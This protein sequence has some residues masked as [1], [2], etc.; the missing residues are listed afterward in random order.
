MRHY[1]VRSSI[2]EYLQGTGY[3][4]LIKIPYIVDG[5]VRYQRLANEYLI[6]RGMGVWSPEWE[7]KRG[8]GT[9]LSK[10]AIKDYAL[11]LANFLEFA[12]A[13][14]ID[15]YTCTYNQHIKGRYEGELV[16]GTWSR[17]GV[18]LA[19]ATINAYTEQASCLLSWMAE[20]RKRETPFVVP[21]VSYVKRIGG[22]KHARG[23][24]TR[25]VTVR[26]GKLR[27]PKRRLRM[28]RDHELR[29]WLDDVY[30]KRE[31]AGGLICELV[32]MGALRRAEAV[33]FRVDTLPLDPKSWH[34]SNP[35]AAEDDQLILIELVYGTK[36]ANTE[37]NH[38]DTIGPP[39]FINIPLRL[40]WRLHH[41]REK[42]RPLHVQKWVERVR[43]AKAQQERLDES[44]HMFVNPAGKR[45]GQRISYTQIY[46]FWREAACPYQGWHPHLGRDWWACS[47]LMREV[48]LNSQFAELGGRIPSA[49]FLA[50]ALDVIRH[51]IQPQLGHK[52]VETCFIYLQ[53]VADELGVA[54]P[55]QYQAHL[56]E[57][58]EEIDDEEFA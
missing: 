25:R 28:P 50:G 49:L 17:D 1:T 58:S 30:G 8:H 12:D 35:S 4:H 20:K 45:A 43:G 5:N 6:D 54:L 51:T 38:G 2:P 52:N 3:E 14:G 55:E 41:Y 47:T 26:S 46:R 42:V 32:L 53:W 37:E 56:D 10:K 29:A 34:R 15:L 40:A 19:P 36:G 7:R 18:G 23:H 44:V 24:R 22:A 48:T 21:T 13:R 39:R 16:H 27:V 57:R 9:P 33:A 31:E 11:W